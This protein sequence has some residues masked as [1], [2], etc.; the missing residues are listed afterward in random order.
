[1]VAVCRTVEGDASSLYPATIDRMTPTETVRIEFDL[2]DDVDCQLNGITITQSA[3]TIHP[4]DDDGG[5]TLASMAVNGLVT[6]VSA[7]L[8]TDGAYYRL[9]NTV[10]LSDGQ[11][12][13]RTGALPV[14]ATR[15]PFA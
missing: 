5:M 11:A 3:W 1:M 7:A 10:T 12:I 6:S 4:D 13:E 9:I 14:V 8:G 2:S 15:A